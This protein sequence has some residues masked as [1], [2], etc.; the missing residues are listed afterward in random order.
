MRQVAVMCAEQLKSTGANVDGTAP[1]P[2]SEASPTHNVHAHH[3]L[4]SLEKAHAALAAVVRRMEE[5]DAMVDLPSGGAVSGNL[6]DGG[7]SLGLGED[8]FTNYPLFDW[9]SRDLEAVRSLAGKAAAPPI[10]RP[11]RLSSLSSAVDD[12]AGA[13]AALRHASHLCSIISHQVRGR[14]TPDVRMRS[15]VPPCESKTPS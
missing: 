11:V 1:H 10:V 7:G 6:S 9:L 2:S 3:L 4:A 12:Y 8:F 13:L 14:R 15:T 5:G